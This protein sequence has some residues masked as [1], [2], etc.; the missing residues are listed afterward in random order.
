MNRTFLIRRVWQTVITAFGVCTIVFLLTHLTPGDPVTIMLGEH[1]SFANQK[2]MREALGLDEPL[3]T[4]YFNFLYGV[5]SLDFGNSIQTN[6]PVRTLIVDAYPFTAGLAVVAMLIAIII[7]IP[8]GVLAAYYK[9]SL[10]DNSL[11]VGSLLGVSMPSFWL[12][13][14][15][16]ILF[17]I[18]L[19]LLPVSGANSLS[20]IVLPSI[21][22]GTAMAAILSRL[23]RAS[24]IEALNED[25]ITTARAKGVRK[26]TVLFKHALAN[27]IIPVVTVA[28]LQFGA[29]LTGAIITETIFA[30][31]GLGSLTV[32]AIMARDYPLIQGVVLALALSYTIVNLLVD[33]T[34]KL[35]DPRVQLEE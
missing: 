7:A 25:Y 8:A 16:I 14:L 12:G 31:P 5:V 22:L 27:S 20:G 26:I 15:L 2:I 6:E 17:A 11:M 1:A 29:L 24:M 33:L 34:Y 18:E 30:W 10:I 35:L 4:Q 19:Q 32:N 9:D 3:I 13:P 28:G 23:T 21:T